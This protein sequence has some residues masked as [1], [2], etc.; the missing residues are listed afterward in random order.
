[1]RNDVYIDPQQ[2]LEIIMQANQVEASVTEF[3]VPQVERS[4][5]QLNKFINHVKRSKN[6]GEGYPLFKNIDSADR[7]R[8]IQV[9]WRQGSNWRA[10]VAG[11]ANEYTLNTLYSFDSTLRARHK[12]I[13][14][15][16]QY[17]QRNDIH[18]DQTEM[19]QTIRTIHT[20]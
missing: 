20:K 6:I 19:I 12:A 17:F 1:V 9:A 7:M 15:S 4:S 16:R 14:A 10:L 2:L 3:N 8:A 18:V 5:T 11:L 13:D